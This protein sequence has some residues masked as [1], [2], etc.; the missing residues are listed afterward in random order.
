MNHNTFNKLV[1]KRCEKIKEVL[2]SKADEY[3]SEKDRLHNFKAAG[4][5]KGEPAVKALWGMYMKHWVAVQDMIQSEKIPSQEW[6]DEK[7]GDSINYHILL[8]GLF[9][10]QLTIKSIDPDPVVGLRKFDAG[11]ATFKPLPDAM[12]FTN[13][14]SEVAK[15]LNVE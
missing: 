4:R 13:G 3:S 12:E 2:S 1:D 14:A 15:K 8:E 5:A 10:E 11:G 7:I 6:L 9:T